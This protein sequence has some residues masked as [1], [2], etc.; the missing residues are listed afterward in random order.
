M[1]LVWCEVCQAYIE[2][3]TYGDMVCGHSEDAH[4]DILDGGDPTPLNFEENSYDV[5]FN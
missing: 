2:V 3:D 1:D 4:L 5:R